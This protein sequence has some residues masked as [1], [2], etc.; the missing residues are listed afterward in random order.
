M[1]VEKKT[2]A[3]SGSSAS[4]SS[5]KEPAKTG[6][7]GNAGGSAGNASGA[8]GGSGGE[9]TTADDV[10]SFN[11][12][13]QG[14]RLLFHGL[15]K[16]LDYY[17]ANKP[18]YRFV[19]HVDDGIKSGKHPEM[20]KEQL[21][22]QYGGTAYT[23]S[24]LQKFVNSLDSFTLS[25]LAPRIVVSKPYQGKLLRL[26]LE[27][28]N[29]KAMQRFVEGAYD[30]GVD[31]V[32][33]TG[34]LR[35]RPGGIGIKSCKIEYVVNEKSGYLFDQ[36][37]VTMEVFFESMED[38]I[39]SIDG[40][41]GSGAI[42]PIDVL[43][44]P[45]EQ[46]DTYKNVT[47][48]L[49][50]GTV[51]TALDFLKSYMEI[52]YAFD[53]D[54]DIRGTGK[55]AK[56]MEKVRKGWAETKAGQS[57]IEFDTFMDLMQKFKF[58]LV[59]F[60]YKW[61]F[62]LNENGNIILKLEYRGEGR[63]V[64]SHECSNCLMPNTELKQYLD[65]IKTGKS[66]ALASVDYNTL[67]VRNINS[68]KTGNKVL[69]ADKILVKIPE[70]QTKVNIFSKLSAKDMKVK[71]MKTYEEPPEGV[72]YVPF[73]YL[74]DIIEQF[75]ST[76]RLNLIF[77]YSSGI[78][79]ASLMG[80]G[81]PFL[82][83]G[84]EFKVYLGTL[85]LRHGNME[86]GE[87]TMIE[88]P[89][90]AL[91]ISEEFF[92]TWWKRRVSTNQ[93][94]VYR[95]EEVLTD[96]FGYFLKELF[97]Y[98]SSAGFGE[99]EFYNYVLTS[100]SSPSPKEPMDAIVYYI[101][102]LRMSERKFLSFYI[103]NRY[104]LMKSVKF[105]VEDNSYL[106]SYMMASSVN[107]VTEPNNLQF[108]RAIYNVDM[109]FFGSVLIEPGIM[110]EVVPTISGVALSHQRR[111]HNLDSIG[112]GGLYNVVKT[113]VEMRDNIFSTSIHAKYYGPSPLAEWRALKEIFASVMKNV[114]DPLKK[115][116]VGV[117][118]SVTSAV[119]PVG[120]GKEP[121]KKNGEKAG[122]KKGAKSKS[123]EGKKP[124][125]DKGKNPPKPSV[126]KTGGGSSVKK[127]P[128]VKKK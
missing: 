105:S 17:Q 57:G 8:S 80:E 120:G 70:G 68:K 22:K 82:N 71:Q 89:M 6:A 21:K 85:R 37:L 81:K 40:G 126:A 14:Q 33:S 30:G 1:A 10:S 49:Q 90:E 115:S 42:T 118:E 43:I 108:Q 32:G 77:S 63:C 103:G 79:S 11:S 110:I 116:V 51:E 111:L 91:P 28:I 60:L 121:E 96:F 44:A 64:G 23:H 119:L 53:K 62:D 109:E 66:P 86:T 74:G 75:A 25:L 41:S 95:F 24:D 19:V 38:V 83:P 31:G 18:E 54:F 16:I 45:Q 12:A 127:A 107:G 26:H 48:Q 61:V 39:M 87:Y 46:F 15:K 69:I 97:A 59:L 76:T 34:R 65:L 13:V 84:G 2:T 100:P 101:Y 122:I 78:L 50:S 93:S 94:G 9:E 123:G 35:E 67:I 114:V 112:I 113:T 55:N 88:F 99:F 117:V 52:G 4:N 7:A 104:G 92:L 27:S 124:S 98:N 128:A 5:A 106:S 125:G 72:Q 3:E 56:V 47:G 36:Y 58:D 29:K 73:V 20:I 102:A